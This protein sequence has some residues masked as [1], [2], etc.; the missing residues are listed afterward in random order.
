MFVEEL[1]RDRKCVFY[2]LLYYI[3]DRVFYLLSI[4][5]KT[6]YFALVRSHLEYGSVVWCPNYVTHSNRI[7]SIQ[8]RFIWYAFK[9]FGWHRYVQFAPYT[10][11]CNLLGIKS[12]E[13]RRRVACAIF[14]FD[15]LTQSN[16]KCCST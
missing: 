14:I 10:F 3:F 16:Q 2:I 11:K 7:E 4:T 6:L 1:N 8:K 15:L 9:R 13:H 12:L 5:L